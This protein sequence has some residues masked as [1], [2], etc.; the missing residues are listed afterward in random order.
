MNKEEFDQQA[1]AM[2][3]SNQVSASALPAELRGF[4][5]EAFF[6]AQSLRESAER[7]EL[8]QSV[9]SGIRLWLSHQGID[10][11]MPPEEWGQTPI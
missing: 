6:Q 11:E 2:G 5:L 3:G 1:P 4:D 9:N 7:R 8:E 10:P